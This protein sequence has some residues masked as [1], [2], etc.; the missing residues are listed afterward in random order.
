M[1]LH[2]NL[3]WGRSV[4][5]LKR[6]IKYEIKYRKAAAGY[7][8]LTLPDNEENLMD[9]IPSGQLKVK[10]FRRTP[11]TV[12]GIAGTKKEAMMLAGTII[13]DIYKETGNFDVSG[14][15]NRH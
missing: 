8:C 14:Y 6:T 7:Y 15:F 2:K 5:D 12:I 9:I 10:L 4:E 1:K 11:R 3:Y 13:Y